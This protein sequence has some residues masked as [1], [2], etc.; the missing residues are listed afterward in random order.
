MIKLQTDAR[1]P[2]MMGVG[3]GSDRNHDRGVRERPK[4]ALSPPGNGNPEAR[5]RYN[6]LR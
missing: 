4:G 6:G 3:H 1:P 2:D 5:I